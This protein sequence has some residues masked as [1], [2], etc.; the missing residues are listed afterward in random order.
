MGV[1]MAAHLVERGFDV[2]VFDLRDEAK[3]ATSLAEAGRS[4]Q[5]AITMLPDHSNVREALLGGDLLRRWR[6]PRSPST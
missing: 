3:L 2:T 4:A 6:V 5:A 1:P